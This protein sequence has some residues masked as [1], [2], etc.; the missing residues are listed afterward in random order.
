M[1]A[2]SKFAHQDKKDST[3]SSS[4][5]QFPKTMYLI[6]FAQVILIGC[7]FVHLNLRITELENKLSEEPNTLDRS[8]R[9]T[10]QSAKVSNYTYNFL[11]YLIFKHDFLNLKR[12]YKIWLLNNKIM[13][14]KLTHH[15]NYGTKNLSPLI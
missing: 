9:D 8:K 1:G 3:S 13:L 6:L 14:R 4:S 10:D 15:L 2:P 11:R 7:V 12:V 5:P